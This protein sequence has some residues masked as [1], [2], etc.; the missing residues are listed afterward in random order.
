MVI[1][2]G[3][4]AGAE[5]DVLGPLRR[6]RNEHLRAGDNLEP[7]GMMLADPGLGISQLI[8]IFEQP[9]IALHR[10]RRVFLQIV[11]RS[12]EDT[13]F[14]GVVWHQGKRGAGHGIYVQMSGLFGCGRG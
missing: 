13:V 5:L 10:L 2:Q 6:R 4:H 3:D 8:E 12:E 1:R 7:A 11:K 14:H 9:H